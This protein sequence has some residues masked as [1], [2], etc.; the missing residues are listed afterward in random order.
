MAKEIAY[1][2]QILD[3]CEKNTAKLNDKQQ[4]KIT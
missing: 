4:C 1:K 3:Q 2:A